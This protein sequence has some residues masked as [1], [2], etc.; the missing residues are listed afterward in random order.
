MDGVGFT[1][2][3]HKIKSEDEDQRFIVSKILTNYKKQEIYPLISN[4]HTY[5]FFKTY[6]N[7]SSKIYQCIKFD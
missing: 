5:Y 1:K 4:V 6:K 7:Y 3:F 2:A